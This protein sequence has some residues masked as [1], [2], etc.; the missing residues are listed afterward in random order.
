MIKK[1]ISIICIVSILIGVFPHIVLAEETNASKIEFK[2]YKEGYFD[3]V[4]GYPVDNAEDY[5]VAEDEHFLAGNNYYVSIEISDMENLAAVCLPIHFNKKTIEI[6]SFATGERVADGVH[7]YDSIYNGS[8][9]IFFNWDIYDYDWCGGEMTCNNEF[10][11]ISNSNGFISTLFVNTYA[12]SIVGT[13]MLITIK[14][15]AIESGP[16]EFRSATSADGEG[17][18]EETEPDGFGFYQT[19]MSTGDRTKLDVTEILPEKYVVGPPEIKKVIPETTSV[20]DGDASF[21][22][23]YSSADSDSLKIDMYYQNLNNEYELLDSVVSEKDTDSLVI[24]PDFAN[25]PDGSYMFKFKVSD[26]NGEGKELYLN[27]EIDRTPPY[28]IQKLEASN[29]A[30]QIELVWDRASEASVAGYKIYRSTTSDG[31]FAEIDYINGRGTKDYISYTDDIGGEGEFY[32]YVTSIDVLGRESEKS[33]ISSAIALGSANPEILT[34]LPDGSEK[35]SGITNV[36][37]I[38]A[39]VGSYV[40]EMT[41][42]YSLDHDKETRQWSYYV[43]KKL[44]KSQNGKAVFALDTT[45]SI[46]PA[47]DK[48][49]FKVIAKSADGKE[50]EEEIIRTYWI[51]N[52]APTTVKN[53]RETDSSDSAIALAWDAS[54]AEDFYEY[55]I[56]I[57]KNGIFTECGR[58]FIP[59]YIVK[60]LDCNTEYTFRVRA[61]DACGNKSEPSE[62]VVVTT[63]IDKEAPFVSKISPT[64]KYV[65]ATAKYDISIKATDNF[66]VEAFKIQYSFNKTTWTDATDFIEQGNGASEQLFTYQFDAASYKVLAGEEKTVYIRA[67]VKD[68]YGNISSEDNCIYEM[69]IIDNCAP[70]APEGVKATGYDG[71]ITIQWKE[72]KEDDIVAYKIYRKTAEGG[73]VCIDDNRKYLDFTDTNIPPEETRYYKIVAVDHVGNESNYSKEVSATAEKDDEVPSFHFLSPQTESYIKSD[74]TIMV[75]AKDNNSL[76]TVGLKYKSENGSWTDIG[77]VDGSGKNYNAKFNLPKGLSE[78]VYYFKAYAYDASDNYAESSEYRYIYDTTAPFIKATTAEVT[79]DGIN[80]LWE[81]D[82]TDLSHFILQYR[83]ENVTYTDAAKISAVTGKIQYGATLPLKKY[84][85]TYIIKIIAYDKAGNAHSVETEELLQTNNK[86]GSGTQPEEVI[87]PTAMIVCPTFFT[88]GYEETFDATKSTD[89]I[90]ITGYLWDFGDGTKS[91]SVKTIHSYSKAGNYIVS[92]TVTNTHGNTNTIKKEIRV[93]E[94]AVAKA[95]ATIKVIDD[96][97]NVVPDAEVLFDF[98]VQGH[99]LYKTDRTGRVKIIAEPGSYPVVVYGGSEYLPQKKNI[100]VKF[101]SSEEQIIRLIKQDIVIGSLTWS[102]VEDIEE[103][104]AAGWTQE[105]IQNPENREICK[106][107]VT[108][109]IGNK[110]V[111]TEGYKYEDDNSPIIINPDQSTSGDWIMSDNSGG[112]DN[113]YGFVGGNDKNMDVTIAIYDFNK[114]RTDFSYNQNTDFVRPQNVV[115][116]I[117]IPGEASW[118]R[119]LFDVQLTLSNQA[120]ENFRLKDCDINLNIPQDGLAIVPGIEGYEDSLHTVISEI[121]GSTDVNI[122][123]WLK[124]MKAGE[125]DISADFVSDL[126][127]IDD[128]GQ[129]GT[130]LEREDGEKNLINMRFESTNP[131]IVYG[132]EGLS[133]VVEAEREISKTDR[134]MLRAGLVNDSKIVRSDSSILLSTDEKIV[135]EVENYINYIEDKKGQRFED[136]G[137]LHQGEIIY[138]NYYVDNPVHYL[139]AEMGYEIVDEKIRSVT[140]Q[141]LPESTALLPISVVMKDKMEFHNNDIHLFKTGENGKTTE[142]EVISVHEGEEAVIDAY[143]T[144]YIPGYTGD[145]ALE[146][147]PIYIKKANEKEYTELKGVVTDKDG[148]AKIEYVCDFK[149]SGSIVLDIKSDRTESKRVV[150][151][152]KKK[153]TYVEGVVCDRYGRFVSG[154]TVNIEGEEAVSDSVGRYILSNVKTG[155]REVTVKK[156]GYKT[157][158]TRISLEPGRNISDFI[159]YKNDIRIEKV[160]S[161]IK[162]MNMPDGDIIEIPEEFDKLNTSISFAVEAKTT[163][164]SAVSYGAEISGGTTKTVYFDTNEIV[165]NA[166]DFADGNIITIFAQA[167]GAKD[168]RS[169]TVKHID[170]PFNISDIVDENQISLNKGIIKSNITLE[171]VFTGN[172]EEKWGKVFNDKYMPLINKLDWT[173]AKKDLGSNLVMKDVEFGMDIDWSKFKVPVEVS[174]DLNSHT[175]KVMSFGKVKDRIG[176]M[177]FAEKSQM[178][179]DELGL[180]VRSV[181]TAPIEAA[182]EIK[183]SFNGETWNLNTRMEV[184]SESNYSYGVYVVNTLSWLSVFIECCAGLELDEDIVMSVSNIQKGMDGIT[185]FMTDSAALN[186]EASGRKGIGEFSFYRAS[187]ANLNPMLVSQYVYADMTGKMHFIPEPML[188]G[189]YRLGV[190]TQFLRW[191]WNTQI[192]NEKFIYTESDTPEGFS[193]K[194]PESGVYKAVEPSEVVWH[195]EEEALKSDGVRAKNE[196]LAYGI[197]ENTVNK[198]VSTADGTEM[199]LYI[200]DDTTR[201][202]GNTS[203]LVY[204]LKEDGLWSSPKIVCD[205]KTADYN[206]EAVA[207]ADGIAAV[208]L[209][210]GTYIGGNTE[211]SFEEIQQMAA[212]EMSIAAAVFDGNSWSEQTIIGEGANYSPVITALNDGAIVAWINNPDGNFT[213]ENRNDSIM[214]SIYSKNSETGEYNWSAPQ[215]VLANGGA[216]DDISVKAHKDAVYLSYISHEN[217]RERYIHSNEIDDNDIGDVRR[218]TVHLMRFARGGW[219]ETPKALLDTEYDDNFCEFAIINDSVVAVVANGGKVYLINTDTRE[220][221]NS[222]DVPLSVSGTEMSLAQKGNKI[223]VLWV[224]VDGGKQQ[225]YANTYDASTGKWNPEAEIVPAEE[226]TIIKNASVAYNKNGFVEIA[227]NKYI[228][229]PDLCDVKDVE[230]YVSEI[231]DDVFKVLPVGITFTGISTSEDVSEDGKENLIFDF[232]VEVKNENLYDLEGY[233]VVLFD[234]KGEELSR[235]NDTKVIHGGERR[236]HSISFK[237]DSLKSGFKVYAQVAKADEFSDVTVDYDVTIEDVAV[238]LTYNKVSNTIVVKV[239][240]EG[241]ID[242]DEIDIIVSNNADNDEV[243]FENKIKNLA[244]AEIDE[245]S[246]SV[247]GIPLDSTGHINV[248]ARANIVGEVGLFSLDKVA[249]ELNEENNSA[250]LMSLPA[251]I[252]NGKGVV[253]GTVCLQYWW[254]ETEFA[255]DIE[256]N[257]TIKVE[258]LNSNL[259]VVKVAE[260]NKKGEFEMSLDAGTYSLRFSKKGCL[261]RTV[262]NVVVVASENA[263]ET[264]KLDKYCLIQGDVHGDDNLVTIVDITSLIANVGKDVTDENRFYDFDEDNSIFTKELSLIISNLGWY[265]GFYSQISEFYEDSEVK[266]K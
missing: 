230:L 261:T 243:L 33:N 131:I 168:R 167:D 15:R 117:A 54:D 18:F 171:N 258:A 256:Y 240:N 147:Y 73:Y 220:I 127:A 4:T 210:L 233:D 231:N 249:L 48:V 207:I 11:Y 61:V 40:S 188:E 78:G 58:S 108:V 22:V 116:V 12:E 41:L 76:K 180:A 212:S 51:D 82:S 14:F 128:N 100:Y 2:Y 251:T 176:S 187:N 234:E 133:I 112:W 192:S 152:K 53:L 173:F 67:I 195:S 62:D 8:C 97:G 83:T 134:Y 16:V 163:G 149:N 37:V 25:V 103:L 119:E 122:R 107:E 49:Y 27:Y 118:L 125:Y 154:A 77:R 238:D 206:P 221:I 105:Q 135:T 215:T 31:P 203:S 185:D 153:S 5:A 38:A 113:G 129:W 109:K 169:Y 114:N 9:G 216:I 30:K 92:L 263:D 39:V 213:D 120:D 157:L 194:S 19:D 72:A 217:D 68:I 32:Y 158:E 74:S 170:T 71:Y 95:T 89:K 106:F 28:P 75:Y 196:P 64:S 214:Y 193:V 44:S 250:E 42:Y 60:N 164:G 211:S 90:G 63:K 36:S 219:S 124:G 144:G 155:K 208:W 98:S 65:N 200:Q 80:L 186:V 247:N 79:A 178:G 223:S 205:D 13:G 86:P 201:S 257:S 245:K 224:S 123:W 199:L 177:K 161:D 45:Q 248:L 172:V 10:P 57:M 138:S 160:T 159:I 222:F 85:E 260:P 52:A 143:V 242:I 94:K 6:I 246:F 236:K 136:S 197:S 174:Y 26:K 184:N 34:I 126:E 91:S 1:L 81:S 132:N 162:K 142:A 87:I 21:K 191:E 145:V 198:L 183:Y 111:S 165:L 235:I 102:R 99:T 239:S 175:L 115:A 23:L 17:C 204:S 29:G 101:N 47:D 93:E 229:E 264:T 151:Q 88:V 232:V 66:G 69:Y 254:E 202:T 121:P 56:E 266:Y 244:V 104:Y 189:T 182:P 218:K 59:S 46:F 24:T 43:T 190:G 96:R 150:I 130:I 35:I 7:K 137:N 226:N 181:S 84:G 166:A 140:A 141:L 253:S 209:N 228:F 139:C 225:L 55:V 3:N 20:I 50:S 262:N 179:T 259:E 241:F 255:N 265:E 70:M 237:S 156:D 148:W 227:Y 110:V 146:G 252:E